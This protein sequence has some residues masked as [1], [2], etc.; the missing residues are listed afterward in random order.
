[1]PFTAEKNRN[2][3]LIK[4]NSRVLICKG[5]LKSETCMLLENFCVKKQKSEDFNT[6]IRAILIYRSAAKRFALGHARVLEKWA[7]PQLNKIG[8]PL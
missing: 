8:S 5:T 4:T 3:H 7:L 6:E 1:M 2:S